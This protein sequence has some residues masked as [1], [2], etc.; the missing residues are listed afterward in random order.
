MV[1]YVAVI[2]IRPA[3]SQ[4]AGGKGSR[5]GLVTLSDI[6]KLNPELKPLNPELAEESEPKTKAKRQHPEADLREVVR[7]LAAR[8]GWQFYFTWSSR[9]SPKGFPDTALCRPPRLIL[10]ELKSEKGKVTPEQQ[11]WADLLSQC[12]G[13]EY[14]LWRP[15]DID[16]IVAALEGVLI[17]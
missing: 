7:E 5:G 11:T 16:K 10:A 8:F 2:G 12:P 14:Y 3:T 6:F 4:P 1:E 15:G 17:L 13:V 9:F